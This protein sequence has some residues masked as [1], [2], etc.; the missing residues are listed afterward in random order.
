MSFK[1]NAITGKL[2]LVNNTEY[3]GVLA[4]APT[5]PQDGWTYINSGDSGYYIYYAGNWNLLA[6]LTPSTLYYLLLETGF[7]LLLETGDKLAIQ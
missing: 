2:D 5:S 4:S 1:F 6:T 3:K 7:D